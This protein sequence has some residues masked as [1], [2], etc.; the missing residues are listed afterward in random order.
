M[1]KNRIVSLDILRVIATYGVIIIHTVAE[2]WW[3]GSVYSSEWI[4]HSVWNGMTRWAVPMFIMISSVLFIGD[5]SERR[6]RT[7]TKNII[8]IFT[9]FLFW[10]IIYAICDFAQNPHLGVIDILS[11][12]IKGHF[13][14]WFLFTIVGLYLVVPI[15]KCIVANEKV[16]KYYLVLAFFCA[17]LIPSAIEFYSIICDITQNDK[18]NIILNAIEGSWYDMH[19]SIPTDYAVYFVLGI[20]LYNI[21]INKNQRKIIY[22][23]SIIG[24]LGAII[25]PICISKLDGNPHSEIF[26]NFNIFVLFESV[27]VFVFI[28]NIFAK[29]KDDSYLTRTLG[30][31][32]DNCFGVYLMH[33]IVMKCIIKYIGLSTIDFAP[34][35][36][37]PLISLI[38]FV[39]C[40]CATRIIKSIPILNK[41]IV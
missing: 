28:D 16:C 19:F 6:E 32:S 13:H 10:S 30:S 33:I 31:I 34:I 23:L 17:F 18:L 40:V 2:Y 27:G 35:I 4:S 12:L 26:N 36:A 39:L 22:L 5:E 21:T 37:I 9:A 14:M 15:V 38:N 8:R 1:K 29:V 7:M 41:Y 11:R 25:I 3:N 20:Y 24:F